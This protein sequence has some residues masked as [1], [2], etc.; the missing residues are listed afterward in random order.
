MKIL[1]RYIIREHL[2]PFFFALAVIMFVFVTKFIVQHIGRLFGKGLP[3]STIFEFVYLN[4]AWM[5]AL[6]V[7]MSVLIAALMAFGRFSADNEITVLKS[8]GINLYRIIT[9]SLVWATILTLMMIWYNDRVLPEFN[10]R[11]RIL[12]RS[13]SQKKPTF[14]LEEGIYLKIKNINILVEEI[15]RPMANFESQNVDIVRP[16]YFPPGADRLKHI[17]IFDYSNP[18]MQRTVVAD[19][20][21]L[22][23]DVQREQLIFNLFDGE[24]HE[25]DAKDYTEYRR[26]RFNKNVFNVE[27]SE[28]VFKRAE[29]GSRGDREMTIAMMDAEVL[30]YRNK[31]ADTDS[32]LDREIAKLVPQPDS[33][34]NWLTGKSTVPEVPEMTFRRSGARAMRQIQAITQRMKN[35]QSNLDHYNRQI[36]KYQVEIY[37]KFSIP[38]ACIVFVL[39]GA[40]LGI[41][42]RKGSLGVG[43][44][45][46]VGFFLIYWACLIGG[47]EL[48]DRQMAHPALAMWFPNIVVGAF[49]LYLTIRTVRETTFIQWEKLP[50]FMQF[51]F[52]SNE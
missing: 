32:S 18:Q 5:M 48:A 31:I 15:D 20:G 8:S 40:P 49:G 44:T 28:Q 52:K 23:F 27:A 37:K 35:Q 50:K 19:Y 10:H 41:R 33:V 14:E 17:T 21:Y 24:I 34:A 22:V 16:D 12:A 25:V 13:I 46:S 26:L 43:V 38:F 4:L 9:P 6:A 45:F 42:A 36:Y 3:V 11:A 1:Q 47:E 51:F 39:I 7:P 29:S 30:S 2:G